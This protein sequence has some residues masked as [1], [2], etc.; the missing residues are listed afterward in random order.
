MGGGALRLI[1]LAFGSA[2]EAG[3]EEALH[4][5]FDQFLQAIP[6]T[7]SIRRPIKTARGSPSQSRLFG[8]ADARR[9]TNGAFKYY[10]RTADFFSGASS[11]DEPMSVG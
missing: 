11:C 6:I 1:T 8:Y 5:G 7:I 4:V 3:I 9:T 10:F 2:S